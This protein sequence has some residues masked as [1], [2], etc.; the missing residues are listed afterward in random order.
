MFFWFGLGLGVMVGRQN[1]TQWAKTE[2]PSDLEL[3]SRF[4]WFASLLRN[5]SGAKPA[6]TAESC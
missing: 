1:A 6:P 4:R 2:A 5:C 3:S